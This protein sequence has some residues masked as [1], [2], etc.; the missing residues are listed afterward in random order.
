MQAAISSQQQFA[1]YGI[2]Q[3][4]GGTPAERAGDF[5]LNHHRA[6][7]YQEEPGGRVLESP[8]DLL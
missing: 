3:V 6:G 4:S 8:D 7:S 2:S 5:P 1:G